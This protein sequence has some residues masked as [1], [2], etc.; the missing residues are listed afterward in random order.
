[1]ENKKLFSAAE[2][3]ELAGKTLD[4][5]IDDILEAIKVAATERKRMLRTGWDY[6]ADQ[7]LW[8]HGGYG[9]TKEWEWA[10]KK[11]TDLGYK[12]KFFYEEHQFVDMYTLIEW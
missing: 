7:D 9:T 3:K 5:K 1:M 10:R 2:A 4:E 11:L 12:V 6:K 8:I